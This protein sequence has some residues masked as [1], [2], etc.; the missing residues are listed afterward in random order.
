MNSLTELLVS[1]LRESTSLGII[2]EFCFDEQLFKKLCVW[3]LQ[4]GSY[5]SERVVDQ[6]RMYEER[7]YTEKYQQFLVKFRI[8]FTCFTPCKT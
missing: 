3:A 4:P 5:Q 1:E 2:F 6:L 8:Q 7:V